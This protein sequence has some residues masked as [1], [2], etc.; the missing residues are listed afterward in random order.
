MASSE[1]CVDFDDLEPEPFYP[2][3]SITLT[4]RESWSQRY[5]GN[6]LLWGLD[7]WVQLKVNATYWDW[8]DYLGPIPELD[9]IPF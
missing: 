7:K 9:D 3:T 2:Y 4:P 5:V 6:N 1:T 8:A